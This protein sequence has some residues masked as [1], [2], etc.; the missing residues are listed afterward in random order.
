M[1]YRI[2]P[3]HEKYK[4]FV[5]NSKVVRKALGADTMFHFSREP[6]SYQQSWTPFEISFSELGS[7][8]NANLPDISARN[9]RLY[10]SEAAYDA[11][12]T[13]LAPHG[14]LLPVF[15]ESNK[16][17]LFNPLSL[18]ENYQALDPKAC[19]KNEFGEVEAIG[20]LEEKLTDVDVFR[21]EFDGYA[22]IFCSD[23]FKS[24]VE[25]HHL[26]GLLFSVDAVNPPSEDAEQ[27]PLH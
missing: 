18:A 11:L 17:F 7:K 13:I 10:L 27:P 12:R 15:H 21:S 23:A 16:G 9:G 14:E 3:N 2:H 1:I 19:V 4:S 20:F 26:Q 25:R 8:N 5:L 22:G 24:A 6:K